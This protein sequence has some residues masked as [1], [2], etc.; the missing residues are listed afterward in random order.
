MSVVL[1]SVIV[2]VS[3]FFEVL[4]FLFALAGYGPMGWKLDKQYGGLWQICE[5]KSG[6]DSC[7]R[8]S[9]STADE[10]NHEYQKYTTARLFQVLSN[11]CF[12]PTLLGLA[13]CAK[14]PHVSKY[15]KKFLKSHQIQKSG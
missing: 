12:L 4:A 7:S 10:L 2:G 11:I 1:V 9:S 14:F 6:V 5:K 3:E 15:T 8:I 13:L